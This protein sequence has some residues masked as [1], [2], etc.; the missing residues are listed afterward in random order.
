VRRRL[1]VFARDEG[2]TLTELP[3]ESVELPHAVDN[4]HLDPVSG[5]LFTGSIP[6]LYEQ[7]DHSHPRHGTFLE[8]STSDGVT[9]DSFTEVVV[10]DGTLLNQ[11]SACYR[12]NTDDGS[13]WG[14]CGSPLGDGLLACSLQEEGKF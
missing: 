3:E 1:S 6:F 11:V 4:V 8:I 9:F 2:G 5:H 14:I 12:V 7:L 13:M 10:H